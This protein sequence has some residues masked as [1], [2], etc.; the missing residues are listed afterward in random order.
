MATKKKRPAAWCGCIDKV[1]AALHAQG[2]ALVV[3]LRIVGGDFEARAIV[4]TEAKDGP[5]RK[6]FP[7]L[8]A[9]FCPFCG[10]EYPETKG[11]T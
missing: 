3:S 7:R 5:S 8:I 11:G 4:S 1:N 9:S 6:K 2:N 10:A